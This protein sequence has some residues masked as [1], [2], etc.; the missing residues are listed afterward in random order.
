MLEDLGVSVCAEAAPL[1]AA[2]PLGPGR[3]GR[4]APLSH[5]LAWGPVGISTRPVL[6]SCFLPGSEAGGLPASTGGH[7]RPGRCQPP[8]LGTPG[9]G[10][11]SRPRRA[12]PR[13]AACLCGAG[14]VGSSL[15]A[16]GRLPQREGFVGGV[17][18]G[19]SLPMGSLYRAFRVIK[20]QPGQNRLSVAA[21]KSIC[22]ESNTAEFQP[23]SDSAIAA[24]VRSF[25]DVCVSPS[26][27]ASRAS[28]SQSEAFLHGQGLHVTVRVP[29]RTFCSRRSQMSSLFVL[30]TARKAV[31]WDVWSPP[32]CC[33]GRSRPCPPPSCCGVWLLVVA[34]PASG[35]EQARPAFCTVILWPACY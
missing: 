11:G 16:P 10:G 25:C 3:G 29:S 20:T 32:A 8:T 18:G 5:P 9:P 28:F 26:P 2:G 14:A 19:G 17:G 22:E 35:S 12:R 15:E 30:I 34:S 31:R 4:P 24:F 33:E 23:L 21:D 1:P 27:A 13:R 7:S 6:S